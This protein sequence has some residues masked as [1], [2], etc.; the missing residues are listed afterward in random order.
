MG[1]GCEMSDAVQLG[2][3]CRGAKKWDDN[4]IE[5]SRVVWERKVLVVHGVRGRS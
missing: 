1:R 5:V 2:C 4:P 3:A